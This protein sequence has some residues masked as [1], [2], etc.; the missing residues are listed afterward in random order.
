MKEV[1]YMIR[2]KYHLYKPYYCQFPAE[3]YDPVTKTIMVD[4]PK[5]RRKP[6]PKD[7]IRSGNAY[8]TPGGCEIRFWNTGLAEN[9][10]VCFFVP[11]R[12]SQPHKIIHPGIDARERVLEA[13]NELECKYGGD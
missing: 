1:T 4:V 12:C 5:I 11:G 13:V 9:F 6:F 8:F 2:M 7:W 10:D 3:D